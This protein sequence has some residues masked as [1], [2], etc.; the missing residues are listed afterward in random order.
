MLK[1]NGQEIN[2]QHLKKQQGLKHNPKKYQS[3][4]T[5]EDISPIW[6]NRLK[7]KQSFRFFIAFKRLKWLFEI[8]HSKKCVVAEA[9]GFSS[10]YTNKCTK[11]AKIGNKFSLYYVMNYS[12]NLKN[13]QEDFVNHWNKEHYKFNQLIQILFF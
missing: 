6:N 11:C 10:V 8:L 13:N 12:K 7:E 5:L 3:T 9:Y 4:L 1:L 2:I